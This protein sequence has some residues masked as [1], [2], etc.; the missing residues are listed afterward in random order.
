M[1]NMLPK[2]H[3]SLGRLH[4]HLR[5]QPVKFFHLKAMPLTEALQ[6]DNFS[7]HYELAVD[8]HHIARR[9]DQP[10]LC[11]DAPRLIMPRHEVPHPIR[12][13]NISA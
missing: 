1:W 9:P 6:A 12:F 7:V 8:P 13:L 11:N 3:P 10:G 2:G 4:P 5:E